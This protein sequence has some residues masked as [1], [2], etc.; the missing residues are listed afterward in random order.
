MLWSTRLFSTLTKAR[1]THI[2][3]TQVALKLFR[4]LKS[5]INSVIICV[6][7]DQPL[8]TICQ[9]M[10]ILSNVDSIIEAAVQLTTLFLLPFLSAYMCNCFSPPFFFTLSGMYVWRHWSSVCYVCFMVIHCYNLLKPPFTKT[11]MSHYLHQLK[12]MH[13]RYVCVIYCKYIISFFHT[14]RHTH[15]HRNWSQTSWHLSECGSTVPLQEI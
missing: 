14:H 12:P 2:P 9:K 10:S 8:D 11:L 13:S 7:V 4:Y 5:R 15:L 3:W 1:K 6:Y